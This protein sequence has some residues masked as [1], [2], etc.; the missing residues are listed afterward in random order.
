MKKYQIVIILFNAIFITGIGLGIAIW[1]RRKNAVAVGIIGGADKPT[2]IS[3]SGKI[4]NK[5]GGY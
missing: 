3:L 2:Y 5:K 4:G 1:R